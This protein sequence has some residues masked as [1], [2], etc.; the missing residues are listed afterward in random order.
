MTLRADFH[1]NIFSGGTCLNYI[2]AG[3]SDSSLL[4]TGMDSFFHALVHPFSIHKIFPRSFHPEKAEFIIAYQILKRKRFFI[5]FIFY[6]IFI[7]HIFK[8][9]NRAVLRL[10]I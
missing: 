9:K 4:I 8:I 1:L 3:A 10:K 7:F 6:Y 2:T 5:Y